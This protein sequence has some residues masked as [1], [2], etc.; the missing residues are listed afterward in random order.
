MMSGRMT[1]GRMTR[2]ECSGRGSDLSQHQHASQ[3]LYRALGTR[4]VGLIDSEDVRALE[5]PG[6][7]CL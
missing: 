6:L 7:R 2:A 5:Q 3:V 4:Q 1:G